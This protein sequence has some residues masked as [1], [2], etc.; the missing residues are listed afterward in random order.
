ML[1]NIPLEAKSEVNQSPPVRNGEKLLFNLTECLDFRH[2][3]SLVYDLE[4]DPDAERTVNDHNT[5]V[6]NYVGEDVWL[7]NDQST[8]HNSNEWRWRRVEPG[9]CWY[10]LEVEQGGV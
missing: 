7:V 10:W 3:S 6:K 5:S 2:T 8:I 9:I 1:L 4:G